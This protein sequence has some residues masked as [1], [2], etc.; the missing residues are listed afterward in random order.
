M[1][2]QNKMGGWSASPDGSGYPAAMTA[3]AGVAL[4]C[5]GSTTTQG[6]YAKTIRKSVDY[7]IGRSNRKTGLIG[8][9]VQ[10][11]QY[12]YGH[13]FSMSSSL[14][15]WGRRGRQ[16]PSELVDVLTRAVKFSGD[17]QT[18]G[19]GWGYVG[20]MEGQDFDEGSTTV[21]QVQGLRS[22]RNAGIP[23]PKE[24]IDRAIHFI[25]GCTNPDGGVVY[26][27]QIRGPS[28]SAISAAAVAS[29]FNAG[30]YDDKYVLKMWRIAARP[31]ATSTT[32]EMATGTIP[33]IIIPRCFTARAERLGMSIARKSRPSYS[34][35]KSP[36][37]AGRGMFAPSS[38]R[39]SI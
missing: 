29:L 26:N 32:G 16:T 20:A 25:R 35:N 21:T 18:S 12:I 36:R 6:K 5:E 31:W 33:T 38:P 9:P 22:C 27:L 11:G 3:L 28:R 24:Y 37:A 7:L 4:L 30:D 8:S 34:P 13:G 19:G 10:D 14:R 39:P 2:N 17:A 15:F 1:A 23:V